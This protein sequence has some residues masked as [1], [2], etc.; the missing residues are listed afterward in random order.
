MIP[1]HFLSSLLNMHGVFALVHCEGPKDLRKRKVQ[2][3][4][5][6]VS[7]LFLLKTEN[8]VHARPLCQIK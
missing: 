2:R 4:S 6:E 8:S 5:L 7:D 1:H 3:E